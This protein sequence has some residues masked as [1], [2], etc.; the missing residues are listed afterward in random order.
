MANEFS[1][2]NA[3]HNLLMHTAKAT[4]EA[5]RKHNEAMVQVAQ[6]NAAVELTK[7]LEPPH[8]MSTTEISDTFKYLYQVIKKETD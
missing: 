8:K 4:V 7:L 5:F 3:L 2:S 6:I 1:L